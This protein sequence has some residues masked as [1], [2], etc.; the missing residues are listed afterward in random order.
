MATARPNVLALACG[1]AI[2]GCGFDVDAVPSDA[3]VV[4]ADAPPPSALPASCKEI[5]T[6]TPSAASG[7]QTIDPDGTG[8]EP[9]LMVFCDMTT[10]G[11]GWTLVFYPTTSNLT[12]SATAYTSAS[13]RLLADAQ[14][15]LVAYRDDTKTV[16]MSFATFA[17]PAQWRANAP[18]SYTNVDTTLPVSIDGGAPTPHLL[19]FGNAS[20]S[21]DCDDPWDT[22]GAAFGRLCILGTTAPFFSGYAA[23]NQ[24][25]CTNSLS[26]WNAQACAPNLRLSIA[27]R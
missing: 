10:A 19:R 6:K 18:F 27:V 17:L 25:S 3:H 1:I 14:D 22:G 7:T 11:G 26:V 4:D 24:D 21:T 5:H 8:P 20:F 15:T 2:A 9:S 13:N 23:T 12:S 16:T